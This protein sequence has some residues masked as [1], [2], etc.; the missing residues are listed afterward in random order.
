MEKDRGENAATETSTKV[1]SQPWRSCYICQFIDPDQMFRVE[2]K[3]MAPA[4]ES[5]N[6]LVGRPI[7][8]GKSSQ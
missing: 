8:T 4:F 6:A 1:I 3:P 7:A 5:G 2:N